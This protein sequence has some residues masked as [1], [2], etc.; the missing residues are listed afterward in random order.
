MPSPAHFLTGDRDKKGSSVKK[1]QAAASDPPSL[2][3]SEVVAE[4]QPEK[5]PTVKESLPPA[6]VSSVDGE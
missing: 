2:T 4:E 5:I 1:K 3:K 6:P